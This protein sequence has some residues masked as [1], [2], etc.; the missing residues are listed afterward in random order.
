MDGVECKLTNSDV[1]KGSSICFQIGGI[2]PEKKAEGGGGE[3]RRH[4]IG[5]RQK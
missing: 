5:M 4:K 1:R 2:V 3:G